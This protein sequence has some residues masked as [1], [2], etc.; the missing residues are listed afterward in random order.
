[1]G[2]ENGIWLAL[3]EAIESETKYDR[4]FIFSD[5][6]AGSR[7]GLYGLD[8]HDYADYAVERRY[9]DIPKLVSHYRSK[10]NPKCY[11]YSV[12]IA[13]YT[14]NV[15][16]E[17]F[18][19]TCMLSGWSSELLKFAHAFECNPMTIEQKFREILGMQ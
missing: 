11:L 6:Q 17:M 8:V 13:G 18:P 12:Q 7:T 9:I 16:P 15:V 14:D 1:M 10:V 2:T 19:R 5:M 4:I 3:K